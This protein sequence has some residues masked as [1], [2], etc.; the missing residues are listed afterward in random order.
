M[1]PIPSSLIPN[2]RVRVHGKLIYRHGKPFLIRGAT[3]GT[4]RLNDS[5][6]DYPSPETVEQDFALMAKQGFNAVRTYTVPPRWLLDRAERFGLCVMVGLPWEQHIAFLDSTDQVNDI[7][8]RVRAGASQC[9]GH[10]A[11]LFFAIGNEIPS[12]IVRYYGARRVEAFLHRLYQTVKEVDPEALVSYVN[13]PT[14]EYLQLDFVDLFCFNVYLE[15]EEKLGAY[16]ARLQ[17][18]AGEKPLVMAEIGLDSQR[19]GHEKQAE[20][21]SWQIRV[22]FSEGCAGLFVFAWTDEWYRGGFEIEDWDFGLTDRLRHPKPAMSTVAAAMRN[23]PFPAD[24]DWP[25]IS[26][27]VCTYNGSRTI[28]E[29]LTHLAALDYPDYEVVVVNDGSTDSTS[30]IIEDFDWVRSISVPNGGLS[31]ARNLGMEAA[32]GEIVAYL[33][34]DAF[35]DPL[36][37]QYI[38]D[39]FLR[40]DFA[41]VGGPN[42]PPEEDGPIAHCVAQS[43]GGP[44][45][46]LISDREAEHIPGCNMAFR[47]AWLK[48]IGGCDPAFRIAGDDVDLC[49]RLMQAGGKIGFSASALVWHHRRNSVKA[50]WKQQANYGR[51]EALLE[52]KWPEKYNELGHTSWAGRIYGRG[53]MQ[54]FA[55]PGRIY[56]GTWGLAPFQAVYPEPMSLG[57]ALP[58]MPEWYFVVLLLSCLAVLTQLGLSWAPLNAVFPLL[59]LALAPPVLQAWRGARAAVFPDRF[60]GWALWRYKALV[61]VLYLMQPMARLWGRITYGITPWRLRGAAGLMLRWFR[62]ETRWSESWHAPEDW[63]FALEAQLR[64]LQAVVRLGDDWTGWDI[65]V[66]CGFFG[67]VRMVAGIEEHGAGRQLIRF[68][69]WPRFS[70]FAVGALGILVLTTLGAIWAGARAEAILFAFC[71]FLLTLRM[72]AEASTAMSQSV[73]AIRQIS[74]SG[75]LP[76]EDA[77]VETEADADLAGVH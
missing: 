77:E 69:I 65:E 58:A 29:T 13:Y 74:L 32:T 47:R 8:R 34:D 48:G 45:Q 72:F 59:L 5:G 57:R 6:E 44:Q 46:V 60:R 28:R 35:P 27:V 15:S 66:R 53:I 18:L 14:T 42:I 75:V 56:Q 19:N 16:L 9:A 31:R 24:R 26:V 11:L 17:N 68:R 67:R 20:V 12:S 10:P 73:E 1:E 54:A 4:F 52:R 2:S 71:S 63:L 23:T 64:R 21:L 37:L 61:G 38:A 49:W 70:L 36:W 50:Y 3:Y 30:S 25:R 41:A 39:T 7:I 43:P 40:S 33:D 62:V 22:A 55:T 76:T 51:A